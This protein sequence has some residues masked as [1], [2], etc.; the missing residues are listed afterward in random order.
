MQAVLVNRLVLNLCSTARM[1]EDQATFAIVTG[2]NAPHFAP[3]SLLGN[4]GAP[5]RTDIELVGPLHLQDLSGST[6][7]RSSSVPDS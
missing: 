5:I 7:R 3:N 1:K 4:I 2:L 6:T